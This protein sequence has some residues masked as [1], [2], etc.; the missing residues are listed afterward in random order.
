MEI[1]LEYYNK[2]EKFFIDNHPS[3]PYNDLLYISQF[4]W[5][6][7]EETFKKYLKDLYFKTYEFSWDE[8]TNFFGVYERMHYIYEL[9]LGYSN[10]WHIF[11]NFLIDDIHN[12]SY[13]HLFDLIC[14]SM[15][16]QQIE[17]YNYPSKLFYR[18]FN[19]YTNEAYNII[20][21]KRPL[22]E[23]ETD[24]QIIRKSRLKLF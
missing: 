17:K 23:I 9:D 22:N 4:Q 21:M 13:E 12:I 11:L 15:S 6:R 14:N 16:Q 8:I 19:K 7:S 5:C 24:D 1:N 18:E 10:Y 3:K 20:K 2:F